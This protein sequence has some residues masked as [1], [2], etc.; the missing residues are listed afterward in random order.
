MSRI[1][2]VDFRE[3]EIDMVSIRLSDGREVIVFKD[4]TIQAW[5]GT[6]CINEKLLSETK[7]GS[8]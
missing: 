4:G 5:G 3:E 6:N 8:T 7:I 1:R 2:T